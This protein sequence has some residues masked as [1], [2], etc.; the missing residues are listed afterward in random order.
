MFTLPAYRFI[1]RRTPVTALYDVSNGL[2]LFL[3]VEHGD[4]L[5]GPVPR[6]LELSDGILY[7]L[8]YVF[9]PAIQTATSDFSTREVIC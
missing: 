1:V 5:V 2:N 7:V 9:T 6:S 4:K 3:E 8:R